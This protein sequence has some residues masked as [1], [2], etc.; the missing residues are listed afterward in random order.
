MKKISYGSSEIAPAPRPIAVVQIWLLCALLLALFAIPIRAADR[1]F[2]HYQAPAAATNAAPIR[3]VARW[4][5][6][7]L[8]IGLS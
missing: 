4:K 2:L 3:H 8:T 7:N 6:L 1:Q 5:K